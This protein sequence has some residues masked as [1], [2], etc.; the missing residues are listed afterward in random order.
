[1]HTSLF[2]HEGLHGVAYESYIWDDFEFKCETQVDAADEDVD[3]EDE[4]N[5]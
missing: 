1:M 4:K 5:K 3:E 2:R